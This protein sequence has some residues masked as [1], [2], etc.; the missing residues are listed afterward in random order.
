MATAVVKD[1]NAY[2]SAKQL[3]APQELADDWALLEEYHNKK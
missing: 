1:V 3:S 2:L